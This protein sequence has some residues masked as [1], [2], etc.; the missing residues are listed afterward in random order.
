MDQKETKD[1]AM[2]VI[3]NKFDALAQGTPPV[4]SLKCTAQPSDIND[5]GAP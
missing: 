4:G 2:E 3:R 1:T 5:S